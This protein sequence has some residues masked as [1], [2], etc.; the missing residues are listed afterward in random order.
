LKRQITNSACVALL[1]RQVSRFYLIELTV[2]VT[3]CTV[4]GLQEQTTK[5]GK[6][7]I[8]QRSS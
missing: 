5:E 7:W 8:S 2:S 3:A 6:E 4:L 1:E